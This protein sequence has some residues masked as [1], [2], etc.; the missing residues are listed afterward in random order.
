MDYAEC[1]SVSRQIEIVLALAVEI[2]VQLCQL[3]RAGG[4][5]GQSTQPRQQLGVR[6][7]AA[8]VLKAAHQAVHRDEDA[9]YG[10]AATAR[11]TMAA[12]SLAAAACTN[13]AAV[14]CRS[15]AWPWPPRRQ[16]T[17][18]SNMG[19]ASPTSAAGQ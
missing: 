3:P 8:V 19:R 2:T 17:P 12:G 5:R 13:H 6:R 14:S 4:C 10:G 7:H 16:Y 1:S 18:S 11:F 9:R 15:A